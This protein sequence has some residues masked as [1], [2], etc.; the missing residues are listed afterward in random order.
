M[1]RPENWKNLHHESL[2]IGDEN[3]S[4]DIWRPV[5][6]QNTLN[7]WGHDAFEAGADAIIEGVM[8]LIIQVYAQ[9]CRIRLKE[10]NLSYCALDGS[11]DQLKAIIVEYG[12][13]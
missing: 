9:L 1:Y 10:G 4:E 5:F 13:Q 8:P 6:C 11:I 7:G 3:S 12:K 2:E